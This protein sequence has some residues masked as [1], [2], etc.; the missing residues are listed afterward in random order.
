MLSYP[1]QFDLAGVP[2]CV[3]FVY[4]A[5][6]E[7]FSTQSNNTLG[8][9]FVYRKPFGEDTEGINIKGFFMTF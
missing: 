7:L 2:P 5:L 4:V 3:L 8:I 6:G 1:G 9:N